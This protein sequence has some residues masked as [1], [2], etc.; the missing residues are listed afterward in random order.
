MGR[1][2]IGRDGRPTGG[3]RSGLFFFSFFFFGVF[4]FF[5][6]LSAGRKVETHFTLRFRVFSRHY[7][8]FILFFLFLNDLQLHFSLKFFLCVN[9]CRRRFFKIKFRDDE[10]EKSRLLLLLFF[11]LFSSFFWCFFFKFCGFCLTKN[12]LEW[13]RRW[14]LFLDFCFLVFIFYFFSFFFL[15]VLLPELRLVDPIDF[16]WSFTGF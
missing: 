12:L 3:R 5:L 10:K 15:R 16:L 2:V 1:P 7:F 13:K 4:F 9:S 8:L 14:L 6:F 11:W